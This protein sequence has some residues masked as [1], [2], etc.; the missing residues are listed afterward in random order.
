MNT[1]DLEKFEVNP[2][3][4]QTFLSFFEGKSFSDIMVGIPILDNITYL[5][6]FRAC[7]QP[8]PLL[9]LDTGSTPENLQAIMYFADFVYRVMLP[10]RSENID[11]ASVRSTVMHACEQEGAKWVLPLS[12]DELLSTSLVYDIWDWSQSD[13]YDAYACRRVEFHTWELNPLDIKM[14]FWVM[15]RSYIRY[16]SNLPGGIH[17]WPIGYENARYTDHIV[18]HHKLL[19]QTKRTWM[20]NEYCQ[21][22]RTPVEVHPILEVEKV[23]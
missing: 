9:V 1:W 19:N 12:A 6:Q 4:W 22:G 17:E 16:D 2:A 8:Y 11:F 14:D 18:L 3:F 13:E 21:R 10:Q 23:K 20:M 15:L 7:C 5:E